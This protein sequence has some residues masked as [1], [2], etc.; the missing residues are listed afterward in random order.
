MLGNGSSER[1]KLSRELQWQ[2]TITFRLAPPVIRWAGLDGPGVERGSRSGCQAG[3]KGWG[4][5]GGPGGPP[6]L[7]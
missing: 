7:L 6:A 2:A 4:E 5:K 3:S 1:Y